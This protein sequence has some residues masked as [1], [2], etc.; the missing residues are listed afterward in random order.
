MEFG[1]KRIHTDL[2]EESMVVED[3]V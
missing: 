1:T 2:Q 3:T